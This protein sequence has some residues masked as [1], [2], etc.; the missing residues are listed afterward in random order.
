MV[1]PLDDSGPDPVEHRAARDD[2][3]SA[4]L[5]DDSDEGSESLQDLDFN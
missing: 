1:P 2:V 3:D 4:D 5:Y